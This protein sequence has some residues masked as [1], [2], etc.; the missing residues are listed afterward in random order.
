[1]PSQEPINDKT[2]ANDGGRVSPSS[3]AV[4]RATSHESVPPLS[5]FEA[6]QQALKMDIAKLSTKGIE[7]LNTTKQEILS[8]FGQRT[9]ISSS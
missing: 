8:L 9:W 2:T 6:K 5:K 7:S 3:T 1:M 4:K